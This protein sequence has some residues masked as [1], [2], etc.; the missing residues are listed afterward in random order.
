MD[1]L[2]QTIPKVN[3]INSYLD[4]MFESKPDNGCPSFAS[5]LKDVRGIP[6]GYFTI[7]EM[8]LLALQAELNIYNM[9]VRKYYD[10]L[11]LALKHKKEKEAAQN[12]LAGASVEELMMAST[13]LRNKLEEVEKELGKATNERATQDT[14]V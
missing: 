3:D 2:Y 10:N 8:R 4:E 12:N 7:E 11:Q 1:P 13:V 14:K 6:T 5:F 9:T